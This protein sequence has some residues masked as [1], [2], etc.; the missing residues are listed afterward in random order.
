MFPGLH[1][2]KLHDEQ[3]GETA[4]LARRNRLSFASGETFSPIGRNGSVD[5]GSTVN[6]LPGVE[7]EKEI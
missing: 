3:S 4:G 5:D 2:T 1:T 6:A 7:N